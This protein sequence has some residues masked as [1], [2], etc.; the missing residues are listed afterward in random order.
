MAGFNGDGGGQTARIAIQNA[1]R[2]SGLTD[3]YLVL[4][5][6]AFNWE[7][8]GN[9]RISTRFSITPPPRLRQNPATGLWTATLVNAKLRVWV[10]CT[11]PVTG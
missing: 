11:R 7:C 8:R 4:A 9:C 10:V 5:R 2:R 6:L 3:A 1:Y